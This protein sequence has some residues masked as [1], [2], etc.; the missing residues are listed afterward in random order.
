MVSISSGFSKTVLQTVI[1][2]IF[3]CLRLLLDSNMSGLVWN[4]VDV[5]PLAKQFVAPDWIPND[6]YLN[7][8]TNYRALFQV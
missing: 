4:E 5:L 3:L 8:E 2:L 1:V 6:W 7:L